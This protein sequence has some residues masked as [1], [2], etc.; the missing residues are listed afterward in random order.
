MAIIPLICR[1]LDEVL[2]QEI[3]APGRILTPGSVE[4]ESLLVEQVKSINPEPNQ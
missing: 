2:V 4:V 3:Q 1:L